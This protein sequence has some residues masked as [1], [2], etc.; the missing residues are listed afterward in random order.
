MDNIQPLVN[1]A[2]AY[3][4]DRDRKIKEHMI[5]NPGGKYK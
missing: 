4:E 3:T 1:D 5:K 2:N